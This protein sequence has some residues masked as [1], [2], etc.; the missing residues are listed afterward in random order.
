MYDARH[1]LDLN[2][3]TPDANTRLY[4]AYGSNL[5]FSQMAERCPAA[6]PLGPHVLD[7]WRLVFRGGADIEPAP[8]AR[9]HG[10]IWAITPE[11]EKA[12]DLYERYPRRYHKKTIFIEHRLAGGER[13]LAGL[14]TYVR[15]NA[16]GYKKPRAGY[17]DTVARGYDDFKLPR[18]DLDA[19]LDL[20]GG[21][22]PAPASTGA[23]VKT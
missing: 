4:F 14:M 22:M 7:G 23:T 11:C 19:A 17:F 6:K 2:H 5:N 15:N 13:T 10:G 20:V 1:T 12:L 3:M 18:A 8:G 9:V 21:T 16:A